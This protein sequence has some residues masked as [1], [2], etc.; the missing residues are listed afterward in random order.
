VE[1]GELA[2]GK[3]A[4]TFGQR[5][6]NSKVF[7]G[8]ALVLKAGR[9]HLALASGQWPVASGQWS[10]VSGRRAPLGEAKTNIT[11]EQRSVGVWLAA[12]EE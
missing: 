8:F 5:D 4:S 9:V 7:N 6:R 10:V 2:S 3:C 1:S 11:K 12:A